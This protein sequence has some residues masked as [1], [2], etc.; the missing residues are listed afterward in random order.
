MVVRQLGPNMIQQMQARC[1]NCNGTG[2]I[3]RPQDR[4]RECNGK[5]VYKKIH[6]FDVH[7][8]KGTKNK[9]KILFRE[10]GDQ[11]PDIIPGDVHV[12]INQLP[13]KRFHREGA[14]LFFKKEITLVEA[15][16]GFEFTI[17][18]LD[19]KPRTL[20][21]QHEPNV[22]YGPGA[23]R[24]IRDEGMP[25]QGNTSTFGNLYVTLSIKFPKK[26]DPMAIKEL[27]TILPHIEREEINTD[28]EDLEEVVLEDIDIVAEKRKWAEEKKTRKD[29]KGQ[30]GEDDDDDDDRGGGGTTQCQTQ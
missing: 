13:H 26:L 27:G 28:D 21:V 17:K 22:M 5:K 30:L 24:A 6:K 15:L 8:N 29:Y 18:T 23:I 1:D 11:A 20:I 12:Q 7:V 14:H 2:E 19:E 3:M 16:T 10:M 4:C 25:M 9:K